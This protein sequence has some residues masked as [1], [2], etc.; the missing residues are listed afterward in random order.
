MHAVAG[1]RLDVRERRQSATTEH[2]V[3]VGQALD[4]RGVIGAGKELEWVLHRQVAATTGAVIFCEP[5][6]AEVVAVHLVANVGK[7]EGLRG[8]VRLLARPVVGLHAPGKV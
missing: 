1:I 7:T 3:E 8:S 4:V 6:P 2:S 5:S